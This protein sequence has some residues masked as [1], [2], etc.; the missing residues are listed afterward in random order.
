MLVLASAV[1]PTSAA[2]AADESIV[3]VRDERLNLNIT[4]R[5]IDRGPYQ[6]SLEVGIDR[7]VQVHVG[8]ALSAARITVILRGVRGDGQFHGDLSRLTRVI[9]AHH[10][11]P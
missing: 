3:A 6:A 2:S 8:V 4:E 5:R 10:V 1:Q 9:A 7:P 11:A